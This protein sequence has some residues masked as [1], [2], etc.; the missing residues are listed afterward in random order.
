MRCLQSLLVLL[1]FLS[2][3]L[4]TLAQETASQLEA[5]AVALEKK[6]DAQ[7]ALALWQKAAALEPN[8]PLA[9]DRIGFLLAVLN[10]HD[11][12]VPHF[13][14]AIQLDSRFAPA[15]FHLGVAYLLHQDANQG[16][17]HLQTAT[18][19][20]PDNFDYRF[21][22]GRALN[23]TAHHAEALAQLRAATA[24]NDKHAEAWN[25]LGIACQNTG[26]EADALD[27]YRRAVKL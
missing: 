3:A 20:A 21:Y 13:L 9:E 6:G 26:H 23:D 27:A 11:E 8:A 17:P 4:S 7:G 24:L 18:E 15:H 25:Q 2:P 10:R 5:N 16:I 1:I 12:A 22:L 19:I 14:R